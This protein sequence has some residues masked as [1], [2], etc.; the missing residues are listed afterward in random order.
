VIDETLYAAILAAV[1]ISIA[2]S[3]VVVRLVRRPEPA[4]QAS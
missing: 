4:A 3:T 2:V 1:A